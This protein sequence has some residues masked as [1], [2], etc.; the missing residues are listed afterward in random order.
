M[1]DTQSRKWQITINNPSD[2]D[3]TH[4]YIKECL[5][6]FK[7]LSYFCLSDEVGE[8]GTYH[9]HVYCF[10]SSAVRFSSL[11]KKFAKAHFEMAKGT[12]QQNRDY[13]YKEGKWQYDKKVD[14][15]LKETHEEYGDLPIERQGQRNDLSD[16][17]DM[18]SNGMTNYDII[19]E[20]PNYLFNVDK[21]ERV[22]QTIKENVFKDI[23]RTLEVTYI[24]GKTGTG[25]T[26]TVMEKYGYSNV[27]RITDYD[28]P[29]DSYKGQEIVIFEEFRSSLKIQ[30]MLNYLDGYPLELPCRYSNKIACFTKVFI[31]SNLDLRQQYEQVQQEY[32]ET[33]NAFLRRIHTVITYTNS[34]ILTC[35]CN[36]YFIKPKH[37]EVEK[38]SLFDFEL[39]LLT[40]L[41]I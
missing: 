20:C 35:I 36:D 33:W 26:R 23:F 12:S 4:S 15:N 32:P 22:R 25:K 38:G 18:I 19:T 11:K 7:S 28:H 3:F 39:P 34:E 40:D 1:N 8:E 16:L 24:W 29:F 37:I 14:T 5:H 6:S 9:T 13:V 41:I 10:F 21:I 17:Y 31:I 2:H 27:F 30:D